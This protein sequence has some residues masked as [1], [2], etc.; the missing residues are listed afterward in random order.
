MDEYG[1]LIA[2]LREL[3]KLADTITQAANA[4]EQAQNGVDSNIYDEE[5]VHTNCTVQILRNTYTG[6]ISIGWFEN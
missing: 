6:K 5:E 2:K 1:E 3:A 4:L